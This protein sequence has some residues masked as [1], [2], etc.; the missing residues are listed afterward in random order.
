ML[1]FCN[2]GE[3]TPFPTLEVDPIVNIAAK[4][5]R[6]IRR[7]DFWFGVVGILG[8]LF[9]IFTYFASVRVGRVSLLMNTQRIFD[10]KN[11]SGFK[12]LDEQ[13]VTIEK[14]V[15]A[16]EVTV[17]NSG[18]LSLSSNSDRIREPLH[19]SFPGGTQIH[20]FILGKINIVSPEN[21]KFRITDD[22]RSFVAEWVYFDP[23]QAF[24]ITLVHSG[25]DGSKPAATARFFEASLV[26]E[27][28]IGQLGE[29]LKLFAYFLP[30]V[31][32]MGIVLIIIGILMVYLNRTSGKAS[33]VDTVMS[34]YMVAT[35]IISIGSYVWLL[36][37]HS[38]PI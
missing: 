16:T 4:L 34:Y 5:G 28:F 3:S 33:L 6:L 26:E 27:P 18:N 20:Y 14:P 17:W 10:P 36:Q 8:V 15:F 37:Y 21:Y 22:K 35:G 2:L 38:P 25:G 32:P 31:L 7:W 29:Q 13:G 24:R 30:F 9:T 1:L 19:L 12:L 23:N 11:F